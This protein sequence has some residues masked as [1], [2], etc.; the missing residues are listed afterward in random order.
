MAIKLDQTGRFGRLATEL[1]KNKLV[2]TG[3]HGEDFVNNLFDYRVD[4]LSLDP[5]IDLA[6]LIGTQATVTFDA[7]TGEPRH[8]NGIVTE[9][10]NMGIT[11]TGNG[12]QLSL[13][14]WFWLA[15]QRENHRIFHEKSVVK[16]IEEVFADWSGASN[17]LFEN[18]LT[19]DYPDLEYTVQYGESDLAFVCRQMERFGISYHFDHTENGHTL[20]M[21]DA[22]ENF[23]PVFANTRPYHNT[24]S[25]LA[26]DEERLWGWIAGRGLTTGVVRLADYNFKTPK[27]SM[28][29]DRAA[30]AGYANHGAI[31][32]YRYP[33]D[34]LDQ[35]TGKGVNSLRL[36]QE[37]ARD[38]RHRVNGNVVSL[39]AGMV[40]A[41][42]DQAV[43]LVKP[44]PYVCLAAKHSFETNY[45]NSGDDSG[46]ASSF[47]GEYVLTEVDAPFAPEL[48]TDRPIIHGPQTAMVVGEGEID[49]D[50]HGR[51]LVRFHWD[52]AGANSMRCRVVQT[53]ASGE[54]GGMIIPRIGMEAVVEFLEGDPDKPMV[55]GCVFNGGTDSPYKLPA[56][57]T[58]HVMRADSHKGSGFNE[59]SFE[60]ESGS[61]NMAIHAQKDQTIR[62]LN[63]QS[64]NISSNRME[65]IG[66]NASTAIAANQMERIGAN[67]NTTV[68]GGGAGLLQMLMPLVQAGGKM[69]TK[70]GQKS[71]APGS[72][73]TFASGVSG[74]L[75]M[76]K[77]LAAIAQKKALSSSGG[78]RSAGGAAQLA[79]SAIMSKLLSMLMPSSGSMN[80]TVE[81][82]KKDT[83][84]QAATEQI[85]VAKN[86][87]VGQVMTTSVGKL[88]KTK[89]GEDYDLEAKK[90]IF[91]RTT[92]H[93]LHAKDKFVIAGP[94]GTIII[95]KGGIT[96]KTKH[97]KI[98]SPKVDFSS[99]APD[100]V[101]ALKSDKPFVQDC[102]GK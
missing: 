9:A 63:D 55:T 101:D 18:R 45:Y 34:Y 71:G 31:E 61:E 20:V 93:T 81:K 10:Q 57:K 99:G 100:Q 29:V 89:V 37:Q 40:I 52:L 19:G 54:W 96:L 77:E 59:I 98:K 66:A 30:D 51:I 64:S 69:L 46:D 90:S 65:N 42:R 36:K 56:N 14:P 88:M 79:Q 39:S 76:P 72:V 74:V 35:G 62:V 2:L 38:R 24:T 23:T 26:F 80:T 73:M 32:K 12:Y 3:F 102:K 58:K 15:G 48:I 5:D 13:R 43:P 7:L 33:G 25:D 8:F 87:V 4:A 53:S 17:P 22:S 94:G 78:H 83:I 97:L 85:G 27:R 28:E 95:D 1:G 44:G 68:G 11:A 70:G 49:C 75:D 91:S 84:G 16:I 82:F 50:A 92:T 86:T 6:D 47:E 41:P 60:A 67:K 21:T